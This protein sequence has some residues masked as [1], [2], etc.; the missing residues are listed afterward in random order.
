MLKLRI[1][2]WVLA[3]FNSL[4]VCLK[5]VVHFVQKFRYHA[6]ARSVAHRSELGRQLSNTLARPPQRG[7]RITPSN[8]VYERFQVRPES[9]VPKNG[10]LTASSLPPN[11]ARWKYPWLPQFLHTVGNGPTAY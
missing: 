7:F 9:G 8:G 6:M 1:A 5:A 3:A 11:A 10:F 2:I 4:P